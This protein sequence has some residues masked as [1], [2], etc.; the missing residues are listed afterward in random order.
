MTL[1]ITPLRGA[2]GRAP[3]LNGLCTG[4][5]NPDPEDK[6]VVGEKSWM[7][8]AVFQLTGVAGLIVII[9]TLQAKA[10]AHTGLA[11]F[12]KLHSS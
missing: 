2:T 10:E 4:D 11:I 6:P 5:R 1:R 8:H 3:C 12:P 9:P 7:L